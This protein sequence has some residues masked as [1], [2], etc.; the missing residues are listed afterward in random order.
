V[1]LA[2][3]ARKPFASCRIPYATNP[4]A[5]ARRGKLPGSGCQSVSVVR[6]VLMRL[7]GIRNKI[8]P[9]IRWTRT[10]YDLPPEELKGIPTVCGKPAVRRSAHWKRPRVPLRRRV[11]MDQIESYLEL[12]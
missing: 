11:S 3:S 7:D 4:K 9:A 5:N 2:Y 1:L 12:K 6:R 8:H 10:L